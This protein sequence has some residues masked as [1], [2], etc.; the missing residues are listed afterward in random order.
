MPTNRRLLP[1]IMLLACLT[2]GTAKAEPTGWWTEPGTDDPRYAAVKPAETDLNIGAIVLACEQADRVRVLQLQIYLTDEGPLRATAEP[3]GPPREAPRAELLIDGHTYP[4]S[5][6]FAGTYAILADDHDGLFPKLSRKLVTAL[7][8]GETMILHFDLLAEP[9][10]KP[11]A[12]DAEAVVPLAG[13]GARQAI[14][15]VRRCVDPTGL[16][17][18]SLVQTG[19]QPSPYTAL[20]PG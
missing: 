14:A 3:G 18:S 1:L 2:A 4:V 15:A 7:Q 5:L 16:T 10:R 11:A 17:V 6:M 19:R 20:P 9:R 8:S 12:F 13:A